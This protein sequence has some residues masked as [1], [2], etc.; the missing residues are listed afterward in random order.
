MEIQKK[1][2]RPRIRL[3]KRKDF[4]RDTGDRVRA[5]ETVEGQIEGRETE[6]KRPTAKKALHAKDPALE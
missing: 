6:R 1:Q 3:L 2:E 4:E 5:N